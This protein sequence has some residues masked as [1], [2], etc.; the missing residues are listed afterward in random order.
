[1]RWNWQRPSWP[2]F[3]WNEARLTKAEER[4]LLGGGQFLGTIKHLAAPDRDQIVVEA[5]SD[6][7]VTTSEIEGELLN[8]DS[9][10]SSIR[11]QLGLASDHRRVQPAEQGIS[12][13]MVDLF[14]HHA[15]PLTERTLL[16]WHKMIMNGRTDLEDIGR[17]RTH[18]EPMQVVSGPPHDPEIHFEAPPSARVPKEMQRF[19]AWF[20][21]TGPNGSSPLPAL[22]RAGIAHLYF[23]SIHPFEDGNGRIG[24]GIAEKALA[25]GLGQA[26]LT[27]LAATMLA[28]RKAY[29]DALEAANKDNEI[30]GWLAWFA[31]IG[32]EAQ[33]RTLAHVD[34]VLEKAKLLD[35]FRTVLNPRQLKVLLRV[36]REGPEGFKG[37]LSAGNYATVSKASP[38]TATRDL[39]DMVD[40][41][42][43]TR[44]GEKRHAR[45]HLP[46]RLRTA[47]RIRIDEHGDIIANPRDR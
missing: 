46:F 42:A 24:R 9:V 3:E 31:G 38:A 20:N 33:E 43:L 19:L 10:Q 18:A 25:Q 22:T 11:R 45:Y 2:N 1:M 41:G 28:H 12:E 13:M 44:T 26:S 39:A 40:R 36:L 8:R 35:R 37:G 23:E 5:M 27:A 17:Y 6:E 30:T 34:F 21:D 7:A 4:F 15:K 29:Y 47:A 14:R 32:L 16:S